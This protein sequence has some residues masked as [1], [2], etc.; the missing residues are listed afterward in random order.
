MASTS[1][2]VD[3]KNKV[4][5][6]TP[7]PSTEFLFAALARLY[8]AHPQS[9]EL[10]ATESNSKRASK[11]DKSKIS[12]PASSS[13][14]HVGHVGYN[15]DEGYTSTGV[16]PAWTGQLENSGVDNQAAVQEIDFKGAKVDK[17]LISSPA[18]G[19]F[20]HVAHIDYDEAHG[21]TSTGV[22]PS[23]NASIDQLA[24]D[25]GVDKKVVSQ[26][27]DHMIVPEH[28]QQ[29]AATA[30]PNKPADS[31][32]PKSP[33]AYFT[34]HDSQHLLVGPYITRQPQSAGSL[35]CTKA[36]TPAARLVPTATPRL[37]TS[38]ARASAKTTCIAQPTSTAPPQSPS[39]T[40]SPSSPVPVPSSGRQRR[41]PDL[42]HTIIS[43]SLFP[44]RRRVG[45]SGPSDPHK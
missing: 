26:E 4:K 36:A 29:A 21:F 3:Q 38:P 28:P 1:T 17:S 9:D 5:E 41:R 34:P 25:P 12:G 30:E 44:N 6:P 32:K 10:T 42:S 43:T 16:D 27:N 39:V 14:V 7:A 8:Y 45:L 33:P 20:T 13:F 22:D 37:T 15:E 24:K 18:S 23:W 35:C 11:I 31:N 40:A 2:P 19:S